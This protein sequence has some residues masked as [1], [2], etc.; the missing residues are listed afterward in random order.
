MLRAFVVICAFSG[1]ALLGAKAAEGLRLRQLT[2]HALL[3]SFQLLSMRMEYA[4][5]PL[6][7]LIAYS[8]TADT[9]VFWERLRHYL[10]QGEKG[11]PAAWERAMAHARRT[12]PG[13][14]ALQAEELQAME[15]YAAKLGACDYA[16]QA[17]NAALLQKRLQ[18][19]LLQAEQAYAGK[20]RMYKS[21][22]MLSGIAL[23]IVLL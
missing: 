20:G 23:A 4:R 19:I 22:G 1:C 21:M 18:A 13:F 16:A 10:K 15:E 8:T 7:S 9:A 6:A 11:V 2:L 5:E 17:R 12:D 3:H 14:A